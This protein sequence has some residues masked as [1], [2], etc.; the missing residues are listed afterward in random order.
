MKNQKNITHQK[1]IAAFFIFSTFFQLFYQ[2][3]NSFPFYAKNEAPSV[4]TKSENH[5]RFINY[6]EPSEK[7]IDKNNLSKSFDHKFKVNFDFTFDNREIVNN[8]SY[9]EYLTFSG[10]IIIGKTYSYNFFLRS[11]PIYL[12]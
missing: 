2:S 9:R 6:F 10:N 12:S 4:I 11:P 7:R 8:P 3:V 5:N 1:L